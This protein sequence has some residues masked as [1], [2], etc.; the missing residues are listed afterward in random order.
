VVSQ[1]T[2]LEDYPTLLT[3]LGSA[4]NSPTSWQTFIDSAWTEILNR[5]TGEGHLSYLVKSG[6]AFRLVHKELT[7]GKGFGWLSMH[8][9]GR[10]NWSELA[11]KHLPAYEAAWAKLNF[12]TDDD[13]DGRVDDD[14][15]RRGGSGAMLNINVPPATP[16]GRLNARLPWL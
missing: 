4:S 5:L 14:T 1:G 7:Y 3:F 9:A 6:S 2:L 11:T 8:Q 13:H 16:T 15:Q 12:R 10:G